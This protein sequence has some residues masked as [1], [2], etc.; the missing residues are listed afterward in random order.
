M[1][2]KPFLLHNL[3]VNLKEIR[4]KIEKTKN[5]MEFPFSEGDLEDHHVDWTVAPRVVFVMKVSYLMF[6]TRNASNQ[7]SAQQDLVTK[8]NS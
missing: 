6:L 8:F 7:K 1:R 5:L 4:G 2:A 3:R